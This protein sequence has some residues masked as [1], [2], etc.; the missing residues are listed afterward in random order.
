M[1]KKETSKR[2]RGKGKRPAKVHINV[3]IP[4]DVLEFYKNESPEYTVLIR[5]V[6]TDYAAGK[7]K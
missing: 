2:L 6:L 5:Q 3:R 1:S 4:A 7:I